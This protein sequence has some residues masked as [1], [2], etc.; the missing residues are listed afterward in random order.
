[1]K[2]IKGFPNKSGWLNTPQECDDWIN[3]MENR[4]YFESLSSGYSRY[5]NG[6]YRAYVYGYNTRIPVEQWFKTRK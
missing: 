5:S 1:M 3:K 2:G 6:K 4:E